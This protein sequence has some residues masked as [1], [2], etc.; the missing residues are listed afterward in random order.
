[1]NLSETKL[2]EKIKNKEFF[3]L[4]VFYGEEGF[5]IKKYI[6]KIVA[7][8]V[9]KQSFSFNYK[10]CL[11]EDFSFD[12]LELFVNMPAFL[13]YRRIF[14]IKD[15]NFSKFS[16]AN[17]VKLEKILNNASDDSVLIITFQKECSK[18]K[19]TASFNRMAKFKNCCFVEFNFK[20]ENWLC[21]NYSKY[22]EKKGFSISN[23]DLLFLVRRC[24]KS[25]EIINVE[26]EK[27]LAF[28]EKGEICRKDILRLTSPEIFNNAFQIA[29]DLLSGDR[30]GAIKTFNMLCFFG[31]NEM[32]IFSA[33]SF[34][35]LDLY[36]AK[37]FVLRKMKYSE[38]LKF[39]D[40]SGKEFRIKNAVA[41]CK[42]F[43]IEKLRKYIV[44]LSN[45]EVDL[46]SKNLPKKTL[47]EK[48][49]F[50]I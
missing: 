39:Y 8:A 37:L 5:F 40:Y 15:F 22:L 49:L 13:S 35:F 31:V 28:V 24:N 43:S 20:S 30:D 50:S 10:K 44:L 3:S 46:K 38:I 6:R 21:K 33:I 4:Y 27:I 26:L 25:I 11:F 2:E 19:K 1:M 9:D 17:V 48:L 45:L 23:E 7:F 42:I 34:C 16:V 18:H 12:E 36:R 47:I 29:K 32:H 14:I 41:N